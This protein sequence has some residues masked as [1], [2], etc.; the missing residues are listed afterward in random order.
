MESWQTHD[1]S[2]TLGPHLAKTA[3]GLQKVKGNYEITKRHVS[4]V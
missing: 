2:F 3:P 4:V 1:Y